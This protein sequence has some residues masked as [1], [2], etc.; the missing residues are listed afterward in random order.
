MK[1][2]YRSRSKAIKAWFSY[3]VDNYS[4]SNASVILDI[5]RGIMV[6][7]MVIIQVLWASLYSSSVSGQL[8][9]HQGSQD[10]RANTDYFTYLP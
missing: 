7:L 6:L 8:V 5:Y 1:F 9:P 2:N 10:K 3:R 4:D